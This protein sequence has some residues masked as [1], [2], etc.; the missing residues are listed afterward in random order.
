MADKSKLEQNNQA[1]KRAIGEILLKVLPGVL[2]LTVSDVLLD[3][4]FQHGRVWLATNEKIL[5]EVEAKRPEIQAQL[6]TKIAGRYTPR[7]QFLMDDQYLG[8]LDNLFKEVETE[9][10]TDKTDED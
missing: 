7:L 5:K 2:P 6:I 4:S 8:K 3:P 1:Y 9:L 10:K